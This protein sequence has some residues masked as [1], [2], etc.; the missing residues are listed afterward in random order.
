VHETDLDHVLIAGRY[1]LLDRQAEASLLTGCAQRG[2]AVLA[3]GVLNSGL[4]ADP[5]RADPHYDYAPA[6]AAVVAT[7]QRLQQVCQR[8]QV[9][10]RAAALQFPLRHPAVTAVVLGAGASAEVR[11]CHEQLNVAIPDVL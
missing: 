9:T 2:V 4:L 11:D 10:L 6:S 3:A 7:A 8:H 5:D 1:T